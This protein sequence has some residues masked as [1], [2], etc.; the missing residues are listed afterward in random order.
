MDRSRKENREDHETT[1]QYKSRQEALLDEE[2]MED[3]LT[4]L[5]A[6]M[7]QLER[8]P[9]G[10]AEIQRRVKLFGKCKRSDGEKSAEFYAKLHHWLHRDIPQTKSPLHPP[11]QTHRG[12][13]S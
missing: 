10:A 9:E 4:Q 2:L 3:K 8:T 11:R 7:G 6:F 13:T 1:F 5:L 12:P